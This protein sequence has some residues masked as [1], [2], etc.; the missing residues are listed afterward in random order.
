MDCE[1]DFKVCDKCG[2][3]FCEEC[4]IN[5]IPQDEDCN[6]KCHADNE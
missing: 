6:C 3:P 1:H 5:F 4:G 2:C